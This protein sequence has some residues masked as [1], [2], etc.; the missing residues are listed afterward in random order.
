[1]R[2]A[3]CDKIGQTFFD[4]KRPPFVCIAEKSGCNAQ[5]VWGMIGIDKPVI[6]TKK[7]NTK[8]P[9]IGE[10]AHSDE[11]GGV[12]VCTEDNPNLQPNNATG[13]THAH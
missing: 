9:K 11:N 3:P 12:M 6:G 1:M 7:Q 5:N 4:G 8:C 10:L 2:G 13:D